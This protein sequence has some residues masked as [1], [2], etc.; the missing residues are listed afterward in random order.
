M[1]QAFSEKV[2]NVAGHDVNVIENYISMQCGICQNSP[3]DQIACGNI[4][5][6]PYLMMYDREAT[7]IAD[8]QYQAA[9]LAAHEKQE[10]RDKQIRRDRQKLRR[11]LLHWRALSLVH[12]VMIVGLYVLLL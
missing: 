10:Q 1:D 2:D 5:T 9:I 8:R 3:T 11:A 7:S 4:S 12:A 6:C